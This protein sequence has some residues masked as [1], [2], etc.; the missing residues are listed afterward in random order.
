[1]RA[2]PESRP[3][4]WLA[5]RS[6]NRFLSDI[7]AVDSTPRVAV[8]VD[9]AVVPRAVVRSTIWADLWSIGVLLLLVRLTIS[10]CRIRSTYHGGARPLPTFHTALVDDLRR[11][12][13]IRT[14]TQAFLSSSVDVPTVIG[15]LR[16]RILL[17]ASAL[18]GLTPSQ[19]EA[20]LAHELAHIRRW[21]YAVSWLQVVVETLFFFHPAAWWISHRLR[22]EREHCCDDV[23]AAL[24][25]RST[26]AHALVSLEAL[27]G[28]SSR[29]DP[30]LAATGGSL[31]ERIRRMVAP[32]TESR[33]THP[34]LMLT[35]VALIGVAWTLHAADDPLR[36]PPAETG[37]P[38]LES[39]SS[40][41]TTETE[42][43]PEAL[44]TI[45]DG[46]RADAVPSLPPANESTPLTTRPDPRNLLQP[47]LGT[48]TFGD[49]RTPR[50]WSLYHDSTTGFCGTEDPIGVPKSDAETPTPRP[51]AG[52]SGRVVAVRPD[53]VILS[54]GSDDGVR[55]GDRFT[56]FRNAQFVARARVEKTT[57][58]L[59][60]ARIEFAKEDDPA[61][62]GDASVLT[63]DNERV[64]PGADRAL[65]PDVRV[66]AIDPHSKFVVLG[67]TEG[68]LRV[69][70]RWWI[71]RG[72]VDTAHVEVIA[73]A[74]QSATARI[75]LLNPESP[76]QVGDRAIL[77]TSASER[78][79][80]P[81]PDART[82]ATPREKRIWTLH[83][84]AEGDTL[85]SIAERYYG[86]ARSWDRIAWDNV[87]TDVHDLAVGT[88]LKV[89]LNDAVPSGR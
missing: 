78:N 19:L 14:R 59:A 33:S 12:L 82:K 44:P 68:R 10:W 18:F 76:V 74:E 80:R 67:N 2:Q 3:I 85:A 51:V 30:A 32:S 48:L 6:S 38:S 20:I 29:L 16:P 81:D 87:G 69:G 28:R 53:L 23:A 36:V 71:R 4:A 62:V 27:R 34:I 66:T 24:C 49:R 15:W 25:G 73:V 70:E 86:D 43:R 50:P 77:D 72:V 57:P 39:D 52:T 13:R 75:R 17:P 35:F 55:I 63:T 65:S 31:L 42:T 89:S 56:I 47:L 88:V 9:A 5:P 21:D 11:R 37:S 45:P 61:R 79:A 84:V 8:R 58:D 60:G 22:E 83:V 7:D 54:V 26:L 46:S 41:R 1:P 64:D 40:V